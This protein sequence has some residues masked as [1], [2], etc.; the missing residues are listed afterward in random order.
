MKSLSMDRVRALSRGG[1][2]RTVMALGVTGTLLLA[3][4][5][6]G[7]PCEFSLTHGAIQSSP[8]WDW[9]WRLHPDDMAIIRAEVGIK[10]DITPPPA[11]KAA[12]KR[13]GAGARERHSP[14]Q[15]EGGGVK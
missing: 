13:R 6:L 5:D 3:R 9:K 10:T 7:A 4:W 14:G 15:F 8:Q 11:E 2:E 1:A 12:A